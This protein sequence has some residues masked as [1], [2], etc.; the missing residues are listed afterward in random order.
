MTKTVYKFPKGFILDQKRLLR[1]DKIL[2]DRLEKHSDPVRHSFIVEYDGG[3]QYG[4]DLVSDLINSEDLAWRRISAITI[5]AQGDNQLVFFLQFS[6]S[7]TYLEIQG[8]DR[9][10]TSL[11]D[12]EIR[13]YLTTHVNIYTDFSDIRSQPFY[14]FSVVLGLVVL[15]I[16]GLLRT[17]L[18]DAVS[19]EELKSVLSNNDLNVKLN[20]IIQHYANSTIKFRPVF[21]GWLLVLILAVYCFFKPYWGI[22][23]YFLPRNILLFGLKK[24]EFER[25][26]RILSRVMWTIIIGFLLNLVAGLVVWYLTL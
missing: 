10:E 18:S 8:A 5:Q 19:T 9:D 22:A 2:K 1:I 12:R 11:L 7:G 25:R 4:V 21:F 6:S 3:F 23:E 14:Y 16:W 15:S 17:F 24:D 13:E 20:F 26:Q